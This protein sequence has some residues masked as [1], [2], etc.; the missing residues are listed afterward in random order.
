MDRAGGY[1]RDEIQEEGAFFVQTRLLC[2]TDWELSFSQPTLG[3]GDG[4]IYG[5]QFLDRMPDSLDR[6]AVF[7]EKSY[8]VRAAPW[9]LK[10][11]SKAT[12][13]RN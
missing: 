1:L 2:W 3:L 4:W 9:M 10:G 5:G 11:R 6:E 7:V 13:Y 12:R 8:P